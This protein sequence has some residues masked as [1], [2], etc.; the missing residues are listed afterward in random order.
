MQAG[1]DF[2]NQEGLRALARH[3]L[4][5]RGPQERRLPTEYSSVLPGMARITAVAR[6]T[7]G[8]LRQRGP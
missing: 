3:D 2:V 4:Y 1:G 5:P 7:V 8:H 6:Q